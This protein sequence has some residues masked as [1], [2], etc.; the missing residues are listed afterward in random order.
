MIAKFHLEPVE[1]DEQIAKVYALKGKTAMSTICDNCA[2]AAECKQE[3]YLGAW[4]PDWVYG[5]ETEDKKE[6]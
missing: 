4:C 2:K 3:P 1:V 5:G 6:R